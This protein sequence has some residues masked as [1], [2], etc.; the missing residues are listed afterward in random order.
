MDEFIGAMQKK[1]MQV[2]FAAALEDFCER[3]CLVPPWKF[4]FPCE[5]LRDPTCDI[6]RLV[7]NAIKGAPSVGRILGQTTRRRELVVTVVRE[8]LA[9]QRTELARFERLHDWALF[10]GPAL[11]HRVLRSDVPTRRLKRLF[12]SLQGVLLAAGLI[13]DIDDVLYFTV[14][15]LKVMGATG[16]IATGR[17]LLQKRRLEYEH[18]NRLVAPAF[19]GRPPEEESSPKTRV[20]ADA[21]AAEKDAGSAIRGRPAGP[22]RTTGIVRRIETLEEGDDV[23]GSGD[24]VVL[25]KPIQS[26]NWH[27]PLLFSVLLRVR[28]LIV[29]DAPDMWMNHISQIARECGVPVVN[30]VPSILEM[31]VDGCQV[32]VDGTRGIVTLTEPQAKIR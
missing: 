21:D 22:G 28:G 26:T 13:D 16:D 6:L 18:S 27:V 14:D 4:G 25:V 3:F 20:A 19:I 5:I 30:V 11:N 29:P 32:E 1:E 12:R 2:P 15:D 9:S 7:R 31:F 23:A 8:T 24:V 10:W 17:R